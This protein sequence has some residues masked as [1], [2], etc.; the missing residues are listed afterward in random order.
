VK[1][2]VFPSDDSA[3]GYVRLRWPAR[4]LQRQGYDVEVRENMDVVWRKGAD[5]EPDTVVDLLET[6]FDLAILQRV[7]RP[8]MLAFQRLLQKRGIAVAIDIDDDLLAVD[9]RHPAYRLLEPCWSVLREAYQEA[10]MVTVST[11]ALAKR[12]G[13]GR[14]RVI[15]NGIPRAY[16]HLRRIETRQVPVV[17]WTGVV[18]SH[19][20]DLNEVGTSV[21]D[22]AAAG[23]I[24]VRTIGGTGNS[25]RE[26]L[27]VLGVQGEWQSSVSLRDFAYARLY[28]EFDVAIVPLKPN[29]F[30]AGKSWLKGLEAVGL[31]VPFV[32]SPTPEYMKLHE[33]GVGLLAESP[34]E[35]RQEL[36]RLAAS[37]DL[38][39]E[40]AAKG[41]EVAAKLTTEQM[42]APLL[43]EAWQAAIHRRAAA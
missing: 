38:R 28:A 15:P 10:D 29:R 26:A 41:R 42:Q 12:Y 40:M 30:N 43:W 25:C 13:Q 11:P 23:A 17:G 19:A 14:V 39:A 22:L 24:S 32:A 6:N 37:A 36:G 21:A 1:I 18:T 31:G 4:E 5:G 8:E 3:C 33:L 9:P 20:G 35:W 2:A 7:Y 34:K 16:L 27:D